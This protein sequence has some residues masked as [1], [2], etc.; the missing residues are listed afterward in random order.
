VLLAIREGDN[1]P[2]PLAAP[3]LL[4]PSFRIR[5]FHHTANGLRVLYGHDR[6]EPPRYNLALL[7]PT[8][9]ASPTLET[10][11]SAEREGGHHPCC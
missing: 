6:L 5:F 10:P 8:V 9:L 7:G 2:L 3:E 4:L 11:L 1:T